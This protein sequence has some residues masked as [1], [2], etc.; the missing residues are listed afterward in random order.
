MRAGRAL[1]V[2]WPDPRPTGRPGP[3]RSGSGAQGAGQVSE[4]RGQAV[5]DLRR[6]QPVLF[7][8]LGKLALYVLPGLPL[9]D[10]LREAAEVGGV[11]VGG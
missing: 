6:G 4:G 3:V 9:P 10:Q 11:E 8:H 7:G 5:A 1:P 2:G